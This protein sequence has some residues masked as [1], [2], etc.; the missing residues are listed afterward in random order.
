LVSAKL[1]ESNLR[2]WRFS[3]YSWHK[4]HFYKKIK[5]IFLISITLRWH[6]A[7]VACKNQS[8]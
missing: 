4:L 8:F 2:L 5:N 3:L 1:T 6:K 7:S